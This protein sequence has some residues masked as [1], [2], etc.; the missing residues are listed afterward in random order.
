MR[1]GI[2]TPVRRKPSLDFSVTGLVYCTMMMFMGL[3]A[4]N[5]Q[6]NLLFGVFGLMIGVLLVS[7]TISRLVLRHLMVRRVMPESAVVGERTTIT[8]EFTNENKFWPSLSVSLGELDGCD[9]FVKQPFTYMLHAASGMTA[10]VPTEVVPRRRGLYDLD[11][12]QLSTSFPFGFIKRALIRRQKDPIL[13]YPAI[14]QVSGKLLQMCRSAEKSGARM[15]PRRGGLDEFY[16]V[17]EYRPGESPRMIHWRRSART[18]VLVIKEM[19]QVAPPRL[20]ILVDTYLAGRSAEEHA[21]AGGVERAIAMAGSLA[22]VALEGGLSVGLGCW[23][24]GFFGM[25]PNHGKRHRR[26]LLAALARL[27]LNTEHTVQELLDFSREIMKTGTTPVLITPQNL[28][29]GLSEQARG[30]MLVIA[31]SS[32]EG[33]G[34]FTFAAEVDFAHCMPAEQEGGREG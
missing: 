31:A 32:P 9:G 4:I 18:G 10:V 14:A 34:W 29:M 1:A 28:Q 27:P 33:Q 13:I 2:S 3:A 16:G 25:N 8:Y 12:Y 21:E 15:R 23:D 5:S 11:H 22:S 24:G 19:T 26:D 20:M 6:A 7:G 17:K 30:G